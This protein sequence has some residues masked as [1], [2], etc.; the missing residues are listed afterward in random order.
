ME[1]KD[2]KENEPSWL[3]N[4]AQKPLP[5]SYPATEIKIGVEFKNSNE[6]NSATKIIINQLD[7]YKFSCLNEVFKEE[8]V[9]FAYYQS[10]DSINMIVFL[11]SNRKKEQILQDLRY[12]EIQYKLQ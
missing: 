10:K 9:E 1:K 12:Y 3:P 6:K 11:P 2:F 8:K 4:F 5:Y 7:D